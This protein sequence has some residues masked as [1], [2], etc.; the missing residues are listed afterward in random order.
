M[1]RLDKYLS[2]AGTGTRSTVRDY[3]R[4]GLITVD[5]VVSKHPEQKI[6]PRNMKICYCGKP[7]CYER[8][9]S[10]C[11][12]LNKP[13]GYISA[14]RDDREQ[15]VFSVM[16]GV[17]PDHFFPVGRLDKDSEGL[18]LI[19]NDGALSHR[20]TSPRAHV[21]KTYEVWISG[22]LTDIELASLREGTDIGDETR[23]LPAEV[24]I[25]HT[26]TSYKLTEKERECL[27]DSTPAVITASHVRITIYEGRYHQ[28]K[29]MFHANR[30]EVFRLK[31]VSIGLVPLDPELQPGGFRKLKPEELEQ[32]MSVKERQG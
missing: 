8:D 29:R 15:T 18:L 14:T 28:V 30:H 6:D 22:I 23:C 17:D 3:C 27:P 9:E 2:D 16:P 7:V 21:P 31:R 20:L 26:E 4:K 10:I 32:L 13:A 24:M 25:L 11:Y 12:M 5:G 1:I 19:T